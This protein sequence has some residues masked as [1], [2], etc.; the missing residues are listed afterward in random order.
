M[1]KL[2]WFVERIGKKVFLNSKTDCI[3]IKCQREKRV[4]IY[5]TNRMQAYYLWQREKV[6]TVDR[7]LEKSN[8]KK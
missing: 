8:F 7:Y 1:K 3:C 4:G 5:I 2:S 6:S